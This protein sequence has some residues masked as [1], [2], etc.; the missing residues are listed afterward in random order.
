MKTLIMLP[1]LLFQLI[2]SFGQAPDTPKKIENI[3]TLAKHGALFVMDGIELQKPYHFRRDSVVAITIITRDEARKWFESDAQNDVVV[4]ISR[5]R[6]VAD[7]QKKFSA[8]SGAY[9]KYLQTHQ[10]NDK[11]ISYILNGVPLDLKDRNDIIRK[12]YKISHSHITKIGCSDNFTEGMRRGATIFITT[13][14]SN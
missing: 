11:D 2:L 8:L 7:Y 6:A 1:F 5:Q 10:D 14:Q 9:K 12:L 3:D 4:M 13:K